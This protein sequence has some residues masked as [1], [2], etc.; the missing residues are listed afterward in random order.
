MRADQ[1]RLNKNKIQASHQSIPSYTFNCLYRE[2]GRTSWTWSAATPVYVLLCNNWV[3][4]TTSL[5]VRHDPTHLQLLSTSVNVTS[6][7]NVSISKAAVCP[8]WC[9]LNALNLQIIVGGKVW[10]N[11]YRCW[12]AGWCRPQWQAYEKGKEEPCVFVI[13]F[14]KKKNHFSQM[15]TN[16]AVLHI[17]QAHKVTDWP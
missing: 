2:V 4:I 10:R 7:F 12:L 1:H 5:D 15:R 17:W 14:L 3:K 13:T 9:S 6:V 11:M 16:V 8:Q